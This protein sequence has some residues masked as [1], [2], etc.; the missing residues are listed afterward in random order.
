MS[1]ILGQLHTIIVQENTSFQENK[2]IDVM[3]NDKGVNIPSY[4]NC[5]GY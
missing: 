4:D 1:G 2:Q 5:V 3:T